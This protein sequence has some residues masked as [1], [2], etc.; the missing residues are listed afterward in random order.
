[1]TVSVSPSPPSTTDHLSYWSPS[2]FF[3]LIP[4]GH[5]IEFLVSACIGIVYKTMDN[6]P[7]TTQKEMIPFLRQSLTFNNSGREGWDFMC[8]TDLSSLT[9]SSL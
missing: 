7:V 1:M 5:L 3:G 9:F 6:L 8:Q 4:L 2:Y